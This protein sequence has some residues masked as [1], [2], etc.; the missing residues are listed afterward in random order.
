MQLAEELL[1]SGRRVLPLPLGRHRG[2]GDGIAAATASAGSCFSRQTALDLGSHFPRRRRLL[3]RGCASRPCLR[4]D[5]PQGAGATRSICGEWPRRD[6]L[7]LLGQ[8]GC[9]RARQPE[10]G[11]DLEA[12]LLRAEGS[13]EARFR[14]LIDRYVVAAEVDMP[15]AE[16]LVVAD[17]RPPAGTG[18][19]P[20][21]GRHHDSDLGG[22]DL[23]PALDWIELPVFD[24]WGLPRLTAGQ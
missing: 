4:T 10:F 12:N 21:G 19:G 3:N 22:S 24:E 16:P 8:L 11:D 14:P 17:F 13:F 7:T 5:R 9:R 15:E 6:G 1:D 23:V 18:V 2:C 20:R